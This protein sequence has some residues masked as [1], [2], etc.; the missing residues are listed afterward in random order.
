MIE[1][2]ME[3]LL[4]ASHPTPIQFGNQDPQL[5]SSSY[6]TYQA[7]TYQNWY[8]IHMNPTHPN[9]IPTNSINMM[10]KMKR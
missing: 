10:S 4:P 7:S 1:F 9:Q 5:P 2:I 8:I 6:Q 3:A